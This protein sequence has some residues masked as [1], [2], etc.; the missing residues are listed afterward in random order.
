MLILFDLDG[1]VLS[2]DGAGG[3]AFAWACSEVL[4]REV[5]RASI[6]FAGGTDPVLFRGVC[7]GFAVPVTDELCQRFQAIYVTRLRDEIGRARAALLPGAREL[8]EALEPLP[9]VTVGILTGNF[10]LGAAIKLAA[11]GLDAQ[12]FRVRACGDDGATRRDLPPVAMARYHAL[13][14][15]EVPREQ[16]IIIGD[17]PKDIDCAQA[18]GCV[19]LAVATGP[20]RR[21]DLHAAGAD[22]VLD[23]LTDT[24]GALLWIRARRRSD[25]AG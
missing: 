12:R 4:Q 8:I 13:H 5:A 7:E 9:G 16:V 21:A 2:C 17:T 6:P 22:H 20:Y 11:V 14:G 1:T 25:Q 19:A 10:A 18:H 24:D 15:R 3:D 23:D